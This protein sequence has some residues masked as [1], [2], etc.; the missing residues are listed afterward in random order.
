MSAHDHVAGMLPWH[1]GRPQMNHGLWMPCTARWQDA[2]RRLAAVTATVNPSCRWLASVATNL[3]HGRHARAVTVH[4]PCLTLSVRH[5]HWS[6]GLHATATGASYSH[7]FFLLARSQ[8]VVDGRWPHTML[9]KAIMAPHSQLA[10][11]LS[12]VM[13]RP[14]ANIDPTFAVRKHAV[15]AHAQACSCGDGPV[16][17]KIRGS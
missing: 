11:G 16:Y 3:A 1:H 12:S 8:Y 10:A 7:L 15:V 2:P 5:G 13:C 6:C 4:C 14:A 17:C 9:I